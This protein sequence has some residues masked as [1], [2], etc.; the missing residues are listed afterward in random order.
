MITLP[1]PEKYEDPIRYLRDCHALILQLLLSLENLATNVKPGELVASLSAQHDW[2]EILEFFEVSGPEHEKD[3]E[4]AVFNPLER[5]LPHMGFQSATT[6]IRFLIEGHEALITKTS[7]TVETWRAI[8]IGPK[9]N[10]EPQEQSFLSAIKEMV[11]LYREHIAAE[12]PKTYVVADAKFSPRQKIEAMQTIQ[13]QH[14]KRLSMP[15]MGFDR[16]NMT[17]VIGNL[18]YLTDASAFGGDTN[19]FE[20]FEPMTIE[21]KS[22]ESPETEE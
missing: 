3:E 4:E 2:Q 16:S 6:P 1:S 9:E 10:I 12:E 15:M 21:R 18:E 8:L 14:K 20:T 7:E 22:R 11:A 17:P 19:Q 5:M 13:F